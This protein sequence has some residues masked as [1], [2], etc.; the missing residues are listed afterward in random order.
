MLCAEPLWRAGYDLLGE[1]LQRSGAHAEAT[2]VWFLQAW[3]F[4][5]QASLRA[6]LAAAARAGNDALRQEAA[7]KLQRIERLY[8][9]KAGLAAKAKAL[10]GW[11]C[12]A[13]EESLH[14]LYAACLKELPGAPL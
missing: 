3:F 9:D 14:R 11:A 8:A 13:G 7:A 5:E 1:Q 10:A 12:A 2:Y 6:L 4:P